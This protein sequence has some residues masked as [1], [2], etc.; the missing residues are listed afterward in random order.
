[1]ISTLS[2]GWSGTSAAPL[3]GTATPGG[4]TN[5][6]S[7][8]RRGAVGGPAPAP[9]GRGRRHA[10]RDPRRGARRAP[11]PPRGA[12]RIGVRGHPL[13]RGARR[14]P[15]ARGEQVAEL[16]ARPQLVDPRPDHRP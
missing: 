5:R 11:G 3:A 7:A 1:M 15:A 9:G 16:L 4:P 12:R 6:P 8:V 14:D 13:G 10:R 2:Y